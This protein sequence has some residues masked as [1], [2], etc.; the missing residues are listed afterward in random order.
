M[1]VSTVTH[2][3]DDAALEAL[4]TKTWWEGF[5]TST[6]RCNGEFPYDG[7]L[8]ANCA[9]DVRMLMKELNDQR[10]GAAEPC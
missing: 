6:E 7:Q 8:E 3:F 10:Q 2:S 9:S 4:L 1:S 5:N